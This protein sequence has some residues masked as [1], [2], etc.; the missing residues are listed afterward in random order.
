MAMKCLLVLTVMKEL[1][2]MKAEGTICSVF[3][4]AYSDETLGG[5]AC[6][7]LSA[8]LGHEV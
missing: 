7:R 6:S 1:L 4:W 2:E 8:A 5:A 3:M